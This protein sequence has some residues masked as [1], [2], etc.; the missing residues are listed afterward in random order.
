M[1]FIQQQLTTPPYLVGPLQTPVTLP[2]EVIRDL[3]DDA[4]LISQIRNSEGYANQ[5]KTDA[6]WITQARTPQV[7]DSQVY[8]GWSEYWASLITSESRGDTSGIGVGNKNSKN[9]NL[10]YGSLFGFTVEI[11]AESIAGTD[12]ACV[13]LSSLAK[14]GIIP[15]LGL[16]EDDILY[17]LSLLCKNVLEPVKEKYP[18]I[19][20]ISG[21]RQVNTGIGQHERG[22]AADIIIPSAPVALLYEI[23]D[24]I[25]K[26]L[27]FDQVILN[28]SMRR[29]AWIHVS[30][31]SMGLRRETLTRDFDDTFHTGLFL[32]EAKTGEDRAAALRDRAEYLNKIDAELKILSARQTALN[33]QTRIGDDTKAGMGSGGD[34]SSDDGGD[35]GNPDT[36]VGNYLSVVQSVFTNGVTWDLSTKEGCGKFTEAVVNALPSEWGHIVKTGGQ[37]QY[38]GH[39]IDAVMYKSPTALNN[40]K[41]FQVVDIIASAESTEAKPAWTFVCAPTGTPEKAPQGGWSRNSPAGGGGGLTAD[42]EPV[43]N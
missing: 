16:L 41:Y 25:A 13:P 32:I 42:T 1:P 26:T 5:T 38:A 19:I 29:S 15:Q 12:L 35:C 11:I 37:T 14:K 8:V 30:F 18:G 40:G 9:G 10:G 21:F 33:P 24:F 36:S 7:L 23:A 31:S 17:N 2:A 27:Q 3:T 28:Y 22:E 43:Y 20:V 6:Y 34:N 4:W 39:A